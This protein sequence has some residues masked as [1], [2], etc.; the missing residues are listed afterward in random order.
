ME[1]EIGTNL[2]VTIIVC[3]ACFAGIFI[4][5]YELQYKNKDKEE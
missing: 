1:F 3:A 5:K 2:T 4:R